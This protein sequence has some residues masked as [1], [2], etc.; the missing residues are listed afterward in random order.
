MRSW[1]ISTSFVFDDLG[2]DADGLQGLVAVE[3]DRDHAA[4]ARSLDAQ[5]GE[6]LLEPVLHLLGRS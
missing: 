4:A 2:L 1:S 6:L 3:D 5:D